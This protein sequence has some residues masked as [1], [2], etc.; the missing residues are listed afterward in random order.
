MDSRMYANGANCGRSITLTRTD[1][2]ASVTAVVWDEVCPNL[3]LMDGKGVFLLIAVLANLV[4]DL[5][6]F[7]QFGFE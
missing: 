1:N 7:N 4:P 5:R 2:G 6:D 3:L